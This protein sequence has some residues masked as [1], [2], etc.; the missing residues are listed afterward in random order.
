[1]KQILSFLL[2]AGFATLARGQS[3]TKQD[4]ENRIKNY[5]AGYE[6]KDWSQV[7][8]QFDD[9]FTFT[10]PMDDHLTLAKYKDTCWHTS[11]F[12][13]KVAFPQIMVQG[14]TAFAIYEVTTTDNKKVRNVEYYT[15]TNGKIK[16]IECFFGT[17]ISYPGNNKNK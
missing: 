1:M 17:G 12:F 14:D 15:F 5:L 11:A 13:G 10:S 6:K 4:A 7:A 3:I 16:S 2:L 9:G 8:S